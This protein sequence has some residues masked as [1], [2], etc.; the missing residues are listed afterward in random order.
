M[1][2]YKSPKSPYYVY[3]FQRGGRRYSG[4]TRETSRRAAEAA[5]KQLIELIEKSLKASAGRRVPTL[6]EA[7]HRYYEEVA[8][9][10]FAPDT[11]VQIL[12]H[13]AELVGPDLPITLITDDVVAKA[14]ATRRAEFRYGDPSK[15]H[16]LPST[17]NRTLTQPLQRVLTRAKKVWRIPLPQEP[18]WGD[19]LLKEPRERVR[20]L[21]YDEEEKLEAAEREDYRAPRLFAQITGLRRREVAG[22]TWDQVDFA[23]EVIR[24]VGKGD[25]PHVLPITPELRAILEP[26]Q[27]NHPRRS[28]RTGRARPGLPPARPP[29]DPR[30]ALADYPGGLQAGHAG[31]PRQGRHQGDAGGP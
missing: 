22:L 20:E 24:V 28:S 27:G 8:Q 31:G 10:G 11:A 4:S 3:D 26:L 19:H 21:R 5:E 30:R 17:V 18:I 1:S 15:G 23:A 14:V 6:R 9:H 16:V 13:L 29:G 25:K 12:S 2:V 7:A